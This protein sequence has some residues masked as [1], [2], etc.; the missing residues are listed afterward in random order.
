MCP[1][2]VLKQHTLQQM[3]QSARL[4][5]W[6]RTSWLGW[7]RSLHEDMIGRSRAQDVLGSFGSEACISE[8]LHFEDR[9]TLCV[10]ACR[11]HLR[12]IKTLNG[13]LMGKQS[14]FSYFC[15]ILRGTESRFLAVHKVVVFLAMVSDHLCSSSSLPWYFY[16][17]TFRSNQHR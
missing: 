7:T 15:G 11:T 4:Q 6:M 5:T 14:A 3:A 9:S 2:S 10:G 8:F 12:S 17:E 13:H 16:M 1:S